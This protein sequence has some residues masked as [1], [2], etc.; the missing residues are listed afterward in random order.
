VSAK[1]KS[2]RL[3]KAAPSSGAGRVSLIARRLPF[4]GIQECAQKLQKRKLL[5]TP[6]HGFY[7]VIL[8]GRKSGLHFSWLMLA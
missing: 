8:D 5:S 6:G 1:L 4:G 2:H 7:V 3:C